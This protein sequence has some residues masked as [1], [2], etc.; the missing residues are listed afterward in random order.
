MVVLCVGILS[1][2]SMLDGLYVLGLCL[3]PPSLSCLQMSMVCLRV[4]SDSE[5]GFEF[6]LRVH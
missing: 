2:P 6:S 3:P 5:A 4:C 1:F